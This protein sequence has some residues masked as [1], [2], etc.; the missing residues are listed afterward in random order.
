MKAQVANLLQKYGA[1][2]ALGILSLYSAITRPEVFLQP[3]NLRNLFNQN[4]PV[5]I[6]AIG[7]TLVIISAGIDL[8]VGSMMAFVGALTVDSLARFGPTSWSGVL[9]SVLLAVSVGTLLGMINGMVVAWG[10]VTPFVVT[11]VGL[12]SFRSAAQAYSQGGEIR[13]ASPELFPQIA[14]EGIPLPF[15]KSASGQPIKIQYAIF[16]FLLLA[17]VFSFILRRTVFGRYVIAVGA[18]EKA[19]IYSAINVNAVKIKVF[20]LMGM[21]VGVASLFLSSRMNSVASSTMGQF[22]ELDAIAAVVIGGTSLRGGRGTVWGTVVGVLLLGLITNMLVLQSVS[23][24]WQ[25]IV[26]GGIILV[27]V[28]LQRGRKE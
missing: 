20:A 27:A 21:C 25:G 23:I 6:L 26:K 16:V 17:F 7:M 22:A 12:L 1:L 19:A 9:M 11:L 8:S 4:V 10:R 14:S 18:N 13:S 15:L 5:G 3:E 28:L 24:Y 2:F